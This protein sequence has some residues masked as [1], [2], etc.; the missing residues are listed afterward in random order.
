MWVGAQNVLW[1]TVA[2]TDRTNQVATRDATPTAAIT[3]A[4]IIAEPIV[5][6]P[7]TRADS[8]SLPV[9]RVSSQLSNNSAVCAQRQMSTISPANTRRICLWLIGQERIALTWAMQVKVR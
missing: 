2:G 4:K 5:K 3:L 6:T 9:C 8:V 7:I 1:R